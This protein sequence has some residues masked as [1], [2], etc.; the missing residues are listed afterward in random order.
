MSPA[1]KITYLILGALVVALAGF[2]M[3]W[4]TRTG[5]GPAMERAGRPPEPFVE[6]QEEP[7]A[8]EEAKAAPN[9]WFFMQRAWPQAD[10]NHA[11][12]MAAYEQSAALRAE[13]QTGVAQ[14]WDPAGPTNIG[15]ASPTWRATPP[16]PTSCIS[17]P[18]KAAC[19][20]RRT[21]G[22]AGSPRSTSSRA[23]PSAILPSTPTIPTSSTPAPA[24]PTAAAEA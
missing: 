2:G 1:S 17:E 8:E 3:A 21:A 16:I 10:I 7:G 6:R 20:R 18:P 23:C 4:R 19:S 15:G 13:T 5:D 22:R 11:A 12:R 14:P 9:E 24:S